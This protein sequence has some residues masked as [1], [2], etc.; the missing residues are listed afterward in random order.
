MSRIS[1]DRAQLSAAIADGLRRVEVELTPLDVPCAWPV[2]KVTSVGCEP[3]F[4]KVTDSDAARRTLAFLSSAGGLPF[5]P[6]P[7]LSE[8]IS[9]NGLSVLCLEWKETARVNA[10]DMTEGQLGS[11]LEGCRQLSKALSDYSGAV[12]PLLEEDSPRGEY[13]AL[14]CYALRHPIAGRL[15]KPLLQIPESERFYGNRKLVTIHGDLQPKNYG[16]DG[17]RLAAVYDTDDLTKGLACE[18]AAYAFTE[19]ARR[20]ELSASARQRLTDLFVRFVGMSSWAKDEW[21]IAVNHAR[22]RIAAR[23]LEKRPDSVFVAFDIA[24]RDKPLR[25]LV[26]ALKG[27]V[28]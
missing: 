13:N 2:F 21:L 12:A 3:M 23:R 16:F 26:Q 22:L 17:D 18:D 27:T 8:P 9:F 6:K 5:L 28:C 11:F 25:F 19:R 7:I 24:R 15:L 1:V 10:E 4:V 20:S 14:Q